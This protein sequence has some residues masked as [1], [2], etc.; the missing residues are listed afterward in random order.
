M[1]TVFDKIYIIS[2]VKNVDRRRYMSYVFDNVLHID[3]YEFIYGID[4]FSLKN[5]IYDETKHNYYD[6]EN[7]NIHGLSCGIAHLTALQHAQANNFNKILICEDDIKFINDLN[8]IEYVFNNHPDDADII[9]FN[10]TLFIDINQIDKNLIVND[11]YYSQILFWYAGATCYGIYNK[12]TINSLI[13]SYINK[14]IIADWEDKFNSSFKI[15]SLIK[16]ICI[17]PSQKIDQY[18]IY[19]DSKLYFDYKNNLLSL[20]KT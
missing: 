9:K 17:E 19:N 18:Y 5:I 15:Y 4:I 14:S 12:E 11:L 6:D 3:N 16:M 20:P 8:Y 2:Y 10:T 7:Y 13:D 1:N